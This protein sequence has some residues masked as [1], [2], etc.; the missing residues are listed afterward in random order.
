MLEG[1]HKHIE[2]IIVADV[3]RIIQQCTSQDVFLGILDRATIAISEDLLKYGIELLHLNFETLKILNDEIKK[4]KQTL[5]SAA[6]KM[7]REATFPA[8]SA[9]DANHLKIP[10]CLMLQVDQVGIQTHKIRPACHKI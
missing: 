8:R 5:C 1:I 6:D 2:N 7:F 3:A 9:K 10:Y 4:A